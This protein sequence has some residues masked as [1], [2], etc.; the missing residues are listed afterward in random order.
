VCPA[1]FTLMALV[2]HDPSHRSPPISAEEIRLTPR[3]VISIMSPCGGYLADVS[4]DFLL[5]ETSVENVL[6]MFDAVQEFGVYP[7]GR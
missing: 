6:T 5:D 1:A 3:E 2:F 4:R 7:I